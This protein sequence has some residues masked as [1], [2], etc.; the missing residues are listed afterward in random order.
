MPKGKLNLSVNQQEK[1]EA[2]AELADVKIIDENSR[3]FG[4][5]CSLEL[6]YKNVQ[7]L[8]DCFT[9]LGQMQNSKEQK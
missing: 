4:N 5:I 3:T 1:F 9:Y 8:W 6:N 2:A 7:S